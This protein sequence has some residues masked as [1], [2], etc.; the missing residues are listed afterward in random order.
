MASRGSYAQNGHITNIEYTT[1]D[2]T[3]SGVKIL[4]GVGKI[5]SL[6]DYSYT[7]NSI[8]A[9][10]KK[11]GTLLAMRFYDSLGKVTFEIAYHPE[12]IINNGLRTEIVH[13]HEYNGLVRSPAKLLTKELKGKY[14][15]YLKEFDLY[16]KC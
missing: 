11:S 16:D 7:P 5:H 14:A 12:P 2:V 8:Y 9:K 6:P 4:Q 15:I 1:I 13:Y 3:T 10:L